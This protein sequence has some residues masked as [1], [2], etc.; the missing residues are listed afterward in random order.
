[1][2]RRKQREKTLNALA[3]WVAGVDE[4][5]ADVVTFLAWRSGQ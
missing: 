1:V 4:A 5:Y 2:P 3:G